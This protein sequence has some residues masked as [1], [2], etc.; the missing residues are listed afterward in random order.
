MEIQIVPRRM[1]QPIY[2]NI[3][4]KNNVCIAGFISQLY[5]LTFCPTDMD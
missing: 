1:F 2:I 3:R 4:D 5:L